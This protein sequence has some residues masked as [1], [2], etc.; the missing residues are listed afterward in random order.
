MAVVVQA[1]QDAGRRAR[2]VRL[3][4]RLGHG[5][6]A[7]HLD[8]AAAGVARAP[9]AAR[10]ARRRSGSARSQSAYSRSASGTS[11]LHQSAWSRYQA[12]VSAT[13]ALE[14]VRRALQPSA[15]DA[16]DADGVAAVVLGPVVLAQVD[17]VVAAAGRA[18]DHPGDLDVRHALGGRPEVVGRPRARPARPAPAAPRRRRRRTSSRAPACRRPTP[19]A[20][21]RAAR[22]WPSAAPPSRDAATA[23]CSSS[24]ARPRRPAGRR[25]RGA[26]S[27]ASAFERAYGAG[28]EALARAASAPRGTGSPGQGPY[29]SS[30]EMCTTRGDAGGHRRVEHAARALD[31]RVEERLGRALAAGDVRLGGEVH[32]P[33]RPL[34]PH[35]LGELGRR[36]RPSAR[37]RPA[38]AATPARRRSSPA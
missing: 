34:A 23:R 6:A 32:D 31:V 18:R 9:A 37:S 33:G 19:A 3:R 27:S 25:R 17:G 36:R 13:A 7:E 12:T 1:A 8:E 29:T 16:L 26:R 4:H 2:V 11:V 21:R 20:A 38:P 35:Q 22:G 30:V 24:A 10:C 14:R 15:R 28:R 5:R